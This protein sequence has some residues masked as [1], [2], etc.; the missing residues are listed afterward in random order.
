MQEEI[1][2]APRRQHVASLPSRPR[3]RALQTEVVDRKCQRQRAVE[4]QR[5]TPRKHGFCLSVCGC[6]CVSLWLCGLRLRLGWRQK[7]RRRRR[8]LHSVGWPVGLPV[9]FTASLLRGGGALYCLGATAGSLASP[10]LFLPHPLRP[11]L[12]PSLPLWVVVAVV[13]GVCCVVCGGVVVVCGCGVVVW[14]MV[15]GVW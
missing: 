3:P 8:R 9:C 15:C 1:A 10:I 14:C 7:A 2:R 11:P 5:R 13:C 12:R 6:L 4:G